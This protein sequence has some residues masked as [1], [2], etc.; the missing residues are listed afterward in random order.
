MTLTF[1]EYKEFAANSGLV[2][3]SNTSGS[4]ASQHLSNLTSRTTDTLEDEMMMTLMG[5]TSSNVGLNNSNSNV[6]TK[7]ERNKA[8]IKAIEKKRQ[9]EMDD[10]KTQVKN[11]E[12]ENARLQQNSESSKARNKTLSTEAKS[13]KNQ[14]ALLK[15]KSQHDDELVTALMGQIDILKEDLKRAIDAEKEASGFAPSTKMTAAQEQVEKAIVDQL[16]QLVTEKESRIQELE[17]RLLTINASGSQTQSFASNFDNDS[18]NS[19]NAS[20][21]SEV[22]NIPVQISKV[23]S[24]ASIGNPMRPGSSN[25]RRPESGS[26]VVEVELRLQEV[27]TLLSA[28]SVEK[29]KLREFCALLQ[30]RV[31]ESIDYK[32]K[33]EKELSHHKKR[34]VMLE[35]QLGAASVSTNTSVNVST[36]GLPPTGVAS[37][38]RTFVGTSSNL[39]SSSVS[40][41][42]SQ[43][44]GT[45]AVSSNE[46]LSSKCEL[47]QE[48][49][50]SLKFNLQSIM[51]A[52][53]ED[54]MLYKNMI[55]E[56]KNVFLTALRQIKQQ[57]HLQSN[58]DP[59]IVN[60]S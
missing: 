2:S 52:R 56:T 28:A 32:V 22:S 13:L 53:D 43:I 5:N 36:Q 44:I 16:K 47:L 50:V 58:D 10:L 9:E 60:I 38:A 57:N 31:D 24:L 21:R 4:I 27:S 41:R 46:E 11:L 33:L 34:S 18:L 42:D 35:K 25:Q 7:D 15:E 20:A 30:K 6:N 29:E 54:F 45:G 1:Q 8:H 39:T 37:K 19:R 17:M 23:A 3:L 40:L 12:S 51:K 48:E 59:A 55:E 49:I 14:V 26:N